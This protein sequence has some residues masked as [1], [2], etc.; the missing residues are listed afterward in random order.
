MGAMSRKVPSA[1]HV[2]PSKAVQRSERSKVMFAAFKRMRLYLIRVKLGV[3]I[4]RVKSPGE[5]I[6]GAF[7]FQQCASDA[8]IHVEFDRAGSHLPTGNIGIFQLNIRSE[9][10]RV[11]KECVSTCR[12]RWSPYN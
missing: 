5:C 12:S 3:N 7:H 10:R 4:N 1:I 9:E 11:G 8:V 6:P 2:S